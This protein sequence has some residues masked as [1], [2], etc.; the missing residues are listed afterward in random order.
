MKKITTLLITVLTIAN[1]SIAQTTTDKVVLN[2]SQKLQTS[3]STNGT[4]NMEMMGQSMETITES[5]SSN[6]LE[7]KDVTATGYIITNTTNKLKIKSKGG[8]GGDA[9]FDSDKKEDQD[10]EIGKTIKDR[11]QPKDVEINFKGKRVEKSSKNE[12]E[13][14]NK[15]MQSVMRGAGDNGIADMFMLIPAGKKAGDVWEDST[16]SNGIKISNVYTVKQLNG[17][18]AVVMVSTL[19]NI[20]KTVQAQGTE[21]TINMDSKVTSENIVDISTGLIKEKKTTVVGKGNLGAGGQQMPM[22]TKVTS[23]TTVKNM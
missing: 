19:S 17:K 7:V 14:M 5:T 23:I 6:T 13:D 21:L 22:A 2:K 3:T 18:E 9:E 8:M 15:V 11:F 20:N 4:V 16:N 12:D 10:T 1:I